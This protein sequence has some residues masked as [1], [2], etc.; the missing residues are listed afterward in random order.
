MQWPEESFMAGRFLGGS[1][2]SSASPAP[3]SPSIAKL[4]LALFNPFFGEAFALALVEGEAFAFALEGE[5][6]AL[7]LVDEEEAFVLALDFAEPFA[8]ALEATDLASAF[9]FAFG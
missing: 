8:L 2:A 7:A 3:A 4:L 5:A 1:S 9:P 6:F